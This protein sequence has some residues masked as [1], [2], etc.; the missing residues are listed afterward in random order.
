MVANIID[1]WRINNR[2]RILLYTRRVDCSCKWCD[3]C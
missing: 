1:G 2:T 3:C